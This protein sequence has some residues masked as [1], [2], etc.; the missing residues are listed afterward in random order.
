MDL[1]HSNFGPEGCRK[2]SK[3]LGFNSSIRVLRLGHCQIRRFGV[4]ALCRTLGS[5]N[6][7]ELDLQHN[8]IRNDGLNTICKMLEI[9]S[10]MKLEKLNLSE[11]WITKDGAKKLAGLFESR[12]LPLKEVNLSSNLFQF[13][14]LV[15]KAKENG[16]LLILNEMKESEEQFIQTQTFQTLKESEF[17]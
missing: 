6:I 10:K 11:N 14:P 1:S 7:S 15:E 3:A 4:E 9:S 8:F 12:L 2:L 13:P 17:F 5:T 16:T